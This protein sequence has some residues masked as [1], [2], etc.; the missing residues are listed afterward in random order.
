MTYTSLFSNHRCAVGAVLAAVL[1]CLSV[2]VGATHAAPV[3]SA[4]GVAE[5]EGVWDGYEWYR[6]TYTVEWSGFTRGLS[7]LSLL[8]LPGC[9]LDDHLFLFPTD[10]GEPFDGQSTG[11][12]WEPGDAVVFSVFYEGSFLRTG[13]DP[14]VGPEL[15]PPALPVIKYEA[16]GGDDEPGK[17]GVGVFT[18]ICN[19]YPAYGTLNDFVI[20][21]HG[22]GADVGNLTGAYP[23]CTPTPEPVTA[24][25]LGLG[26]GGL[27][28]ARRRG[29]K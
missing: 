13:G 4:V 21:K 1:V 10:L 15:S 3:I 16:V 23:S 12:E 26:L 9:A 28:A 11:A 29:R 5:V 25:L 24:A 7:H 8:Q 19:V 6:Y 27:I 14:S 17:S 2:G 22:A 18:F 20:V